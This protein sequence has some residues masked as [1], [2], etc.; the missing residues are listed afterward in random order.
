MFE[1]YRPSQIRE[2][3]SVDLEPGTKAPRGAN[4]DA[5]TKRRGCERGMCERRY[6]RGMVECANH[7]I[8]MG[9]SIVPRGYVR[10][11]ETL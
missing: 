8:G 9:A 2:D 11:V 6:T 3:G 7:R 5:L 10:I 1:L 4:G